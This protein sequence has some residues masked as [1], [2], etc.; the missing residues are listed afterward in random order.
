MILEKQKSNAAGRSG[1]T[2]W[3]RW[4]GFG[5]CGL[6]AMLIGCQTPEIGDEP[7]A[8]EL[9]DLPAGVGEAYR[10]L[11]SSSL[12]L[13]ERTDAAE[14]LIEIEDFS[15]DRAL[16][17]ALGRAQSQLTWRA[18]LQA[19][20]T[21]PGAVPRGL[22]RPMLAMLYSVDESLVM[23]VVL[24]MGRYEE[25]EMIDRLRLTANTP[26]L[27]PRERAR[28]I[29]ALGTNRVQPT[30]DLLVAL[31]GLTQPT[32][33]QT[34]AYAALSSLTGIDRFGA[35]R[36]KWTVWWD[37]ARELKPINW[38]RM[39]VDNFAR[40]AAVG[41]ATDQQVVERL[42]E[43]ERELYRASS[44][45][46]QAGVLAYMLESSLVATRLLALDL[47]Q[48]RMVQGESFGEPLR[49]AVRNLLDDEDSAEVRWVA[50][51]VLRDLADEKAAD[52]A[53]QRLQNNEEH[54]SRVQVAYLQLLARMPRK[55]VTDAAFD[56]LQEPGL[57]AD[58]SAALASISK[59]QMLPPK[60]AEAVL[61]RLRTY[62][63]NGQRPSPPLIRL[64]GLIGKNDD[65]KRIEGWIDDPDDVI[66]QAAAQ[67]WADSPTRSL[68]ILASRAEDPIIQPIVLRAAAQRGQD[69][70]TL[71]KLAANPPSQSQ[72]VPVWERAL[73]AMAGQVPARDA[74]TT[75]RRLAT[76]RK[77]NPLVE[78]FLTSAVDAAIR[79]GDN[80][81]PG[82][83]AYFELRLERGANRLTMD[84]PDLAII[85][86]EFLLDQRHSTTP[87]PAAPPA[88]TGPQRDE[89]YRGLIPAYLQANRIDNA[90]TTARAFFAD[91]SNPSRIDPAATDDP[92]MGNFIRTAHRAA[93]LGRTESAKQIV[94]GLRLLLGPNN[95]GR[96][97]LQ[98]A[99][100]MRLLDEKLQ[101]T[102]S[103]RTP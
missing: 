24:A 12:G 75:A 79:R 88:L 32:E 38:Q 30:A 22:W 4:V 94:D 56:L 19:V 27:P 77:D 78:T 18:V 85:D 54:V 65:W 34:A 6:T 9:R 13:A 55:E 82:A 31:T 64:L 20:A 101:Q 48:T 3:R 102:Q 72:V 21:Y 49:A 46:D 23:D 63:S 84:E 7:V 89:L 66:R 92:L 74:L 57:R 26:T 90:F 58:A 103:G 53:A 28:A 71:R 47:S 59:A 51:E 17:A 10:R 1:V 43:A 5:I 44:V 61:D 70:E 45:Q 97:N 42:R 62:L 91:P 36:L 83:A 50:A 73:V 98:L 14:R 68:A 40:K 96:I 15:A 29:A 39:L 93:D 69:P 81:G 11:T 80:Q 25:S 100:Q 35:D 41:R 16:A 86:Y 67:A 95:P 76:D 99:Q 33:V 2:A 60:R 37:M 8:V 87:G 52:L